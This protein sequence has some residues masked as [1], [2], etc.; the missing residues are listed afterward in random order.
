MALCLAAAAP[1]YAVKEWYDHYLEARDR[2]LP[3][4]RY[5]EALKSL[6]E[7]IRLKPTS[8]LNER[9]YGLAFENYLPYYQMGLCYMGLA[10]YNSAIRFFNMEEKQ[11]AIRR[12][13][14]LQRELIRKRQEAEDLE[15]QRLAR[16]QRQESDRLLREAAELR[17][18]R[19]FEDALA[20]LAQAQKAAENLD[21][22]TQRQVAETRDRVR[23]ELAAAQEAE[24]R[25]R[26]IEEALGEARRLLEADSL[27]EAVVRFDVV[28]E[29]DPAHPEASSGKRE[30]QQRIRA[31]QTRAELRA[32]LQEGR[33]LLDA[34]RAEDALR[35]LTE[36][37]ADPSLREARELLER[38]QKTAEALRA[39]RE[40]QAAVDARMAAGEARLGERK[41]PEAQVQFEA[42]LRLDPGNARARERL[43]FAERMTGEALFARFL[44]NQ[45]PL[46]AF[47]E[48]RQ[49]RIELDTP[50]VAVVGVASDDRA[51]ER[52]EFVL[53]GRPV[54]QV[55]PAP[56]PDLQSQR[57]LRFDRVL[58][59]APGANTITVTAF[60]A[61]GVS[62]SETFEVTRR[63]RF[64]ETEAFLPAAGAGALALIGVGLGVQRARRS[65][66]LRRRFNPYIAGA[67][68]REPDMFYGREKLMARIL[69]VL[70]HNSLMVTGERRIGKTSFLYHL[71]RR[72]AED[73]GT[74]YQFFP[75]LVDLQG[76]SEADFFHSAM[77]DV[78]EGLAL[79]PEAAA[80]LRFRPE[81][82]E[83]D[84]R[85]FSHDLQRLVEELKKRTSRKVKLALLIDEVDVLNEFSE[86]VNQ[87]LRSIFM[88][89][90]SE[91]LVA[92][93]S[94][95]G[96]RRSWKSEGSPWYNFFDEVE[97]T[98]LSREDAEAL[99]R[100]PVEGFFRFRPE[101]VQAILDAAG[102]RPYLIQKLCVHAVNRMLEAGRT[103]IERGDVDAVSPTV[104]ADIED[105]AAG[106]RAVAD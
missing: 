90:F 14:N 103:T 88:K 87:R 45:P 72:L 56:R 66:A 86:R 17:R 37:A 4:R 106:Q 94:G 25:A 46:L 43:S 97:I 6:Q 89:T 70:H 7:A 33:A 51:V 31:S 91:H 83:Y 48:P 3:A 58:D 50:T 16:V 73:E 78:V 13:V 63:L 42:V 24:V 57:N 102:G 79:S 98:P 26:R 12:D 21:V 64:Y 29:L 105:P 93:M 74:E 82:D 28:L 84:G 39:Q 27:A 53:A 19:R 55:V 10:D 9:T 41:W 71:R 62:V 69:N 35:P 11:G 20:R 52:V 44:P 85:D 65:R 80:A 30:A 2:L 15:R 23:A 54:G 81:Q 68:V 96:I 75:V 77:A 5:D 47:F 59:L 67:P 100:E 32:R 92:V 34:G 18:A 49:P 36:A 8:G 1:A 99:V 38:A 76:V 61:Q 60:D 101:A 95:V 40:L 22:D 104:L